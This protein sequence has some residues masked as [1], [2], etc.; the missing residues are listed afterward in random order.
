MR[1]GRQQ[2][3]VGGW[4]ERHN[5]VPRNNE[6]EIGTASDGKEGETLDVLWESNISTG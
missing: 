4:E 2:T 6:N 1:K 5:K 3:E